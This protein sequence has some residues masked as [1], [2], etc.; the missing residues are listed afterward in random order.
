MQL[1][2]RLCIGFIDTAL[3]CFVPY[4]LGERCMFA[5]KGSTI[6]TTEFLWVTILHATELNKVSQPYEV[7]AQ[8]VLVICKMYDCIWDCYN[9]I[10]WKQVTFFLLLL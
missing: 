10:Q 2:G 7:E 9:V 4:V 1:H 3:F 8:D 5:Y 6:T